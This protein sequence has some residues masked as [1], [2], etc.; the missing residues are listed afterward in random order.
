MKILS[1]SYCFPNSTNKNWGIF[2]FQRLAALAKIQDLK[3]C[4][5]VPWFPFLINKDVQKSGIELWEGLEVHRP[6]FFYTP[7]IFKNKD[8]RLYA[9]G[10]RTWFLKLCKEWKPDIL[11][12]HFVWPDGVGVSLLARELGIPYVITLRGKLYECIKIS[13]QRKQCADA[14]KN[15]AAVISV[16]GLMAGEAIKLGVDKD[17]ITIIPNGVDTDV[18][19]IKDKRMC[20]QKLDLPMDKRLLV[21]VAHLGHRK[22]HHEVIQAL[23]GLP[24][25]VNLVLVGGPAQGGTAEELKALAN[26]AGVGDKL[27]LTG[28]QPYERI[29]LYFGAADASVLASYREGCP[30]A[31]LESLACGTPV[32]ASDVGAVRD[33][34]PVPDAGRIVPPRTVEPLEKAMADVLSHEWSPEDVV[35]SSRIRSW[36]QVAEEVQKIFKD[37]VYSRREEI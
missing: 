35:N 12:A 16:S 24:D 19:S 11:D 23:A 33:I 26:K 6:R 27:I 20:R 30:N 37:V 2:V 34:L 13:S 29:P 31:V 5:P 36:N 7:G 1:F 28:P 22:G 8:A 4:S 3:V 21:T 9:R 25:D 10:I 32:V 17:R 14:L 18:F 15:A